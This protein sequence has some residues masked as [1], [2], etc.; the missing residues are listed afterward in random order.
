MDL[1]E[2]IEELTRKEHYTFSDLLDIVAVLRSEQ[3]CPWDRE[4]DHGD[5][6]TCL[7][8]ET[9]EVAEAIDN[10]DAVLLREELG[11]L[12]FQVVFHAQ[13]E[14]EKGVFCMGDVIDGIA[15][16]MVHRHPHV[17]GAVQ[18]ANSGEVLQNWEAIKTLEKQRN[19][20]EEKLKAIPPMMPALMRA[21]KVEKKLQKGEENTP[22]VQLAA[23]RA[24]LDRLETAMGQA[25][26]SEQMGDV[27]LG[28]T[29]LSRSL[30]LD[31]EHTLMQAT[32][33]LI[34]KAVREA[35]KTEK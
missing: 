14:D 3:G 28:V 32:D 35:D 13:I 30:G 22:E 25:D 8:E 20:L 26:V 4:Q 1:S 31:A 34:E 17:F 18:V 6:R 2:K 16:K 10:A 9:Y 23:L 12:L 27:L 15:K 5:I 21:A 19:T 29:A 7:I 11:D 24:Q 33:R